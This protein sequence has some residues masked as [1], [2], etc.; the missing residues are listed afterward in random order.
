[1]RLAEI[2]A[3]LPRVC[4]TGVKRNTQG[5]QKKWN[6]YKLHI[7]VTDGGIPVSPLLTSAS[8]HDSHPFANPLQ[9]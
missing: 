5:Y 7:E 8:L 9:T 3:E 6:S 1:M 2:L 4:E